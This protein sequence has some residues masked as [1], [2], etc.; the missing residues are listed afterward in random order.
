MEPTPQLRTE[1]TRT[2]ADADSIGSSPKRPSPARVSNQRGRSEPAHPVSDLPKPECPDRDSL[3]RGLEWLLARQREDGCWIGQLFSNQTLEAELILFEHVMDLPPNESRR[4]KIIDTLWH[5]RRDDGTWSIYPGAPTGDP[6]A[7]VESYVALRLAG[8]G[9]D[10]PRL[11]KTREW[12]LENDAMVQVR[13]FTRYWLAIVG[14]IS[15]DEV[16]AL[17]PEHVLIPDFAPLSLAQFASWARVTMVPLAIV[18]ARRVVKHLPEGARCDELFPG[19]RKKAGPKKDL[20]TSG[21]WGKAFRLVD[22][23][24]RTYARSPWRPGR[25][26]A[27][28]LCR[29]WIIA[30]QESDG[31]WGG[32]QPPWFYSLIAL[33]AEGYP[34]DH[35]VMRAGL[36]ALSFPWVWETDDRC[37]L[38]PSVSTVWDTVLTL[39][40]AFEAN[41]DLEDERVLKGVE[42]V[43]DQQVLQPF[44]G[45]AGGWAFEPANRTYPDVDDT[46]IAVLMLA[47]AQ[48]ALSKGGEHARS[49]S[50]R[51]GPAIEKGIEFL[52]ALQCK[53]GG[54]AAFDKDQDARLLTRIPFC[55]FGEVLDPPSVD[56]TAHVLEALAEAGCRRG[57][58]VVDR[59]IEWIRVQQEADGSWFGRWGVN[60]VYGT[61]QVLAGLAALGL[62]TEIGWID[63][64]MQWLLQAQN[65]DGGFGESCASYCN[66]HLRGVGTSTPS[67]TGWGLA[68]LL[69]GSGKSANRDAIDSALAWLRS[70]QRRDGRWPETAYTGTGFPGYGF[71]GRTSEGKADEVRDTSLQRAFMMRYEY[72][73][74]VFPLI[75]IARAQN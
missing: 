51:C 47:K 30:R 38:Q 28:Q 64:G 11:V 13:A 55:D 69:A 71:G 14:E 53:E 35:P 67:Q 12:I 19:G 8:Y 2:T 70:A 5:E 42:W 59:A 54:W 7:T 25:E 15:W 66:E 6:S 27:I 17:P 45:P 75:G 49:I 48:K 62:S 73:S 39:L 46:S 58:P 72:Y 9:P 63:R 18:S 41:I 24:L 32:I 29:E 65:D 20:Q 40:A 23:V 21:A 52:L 4:K 43:I 1:T 22:Q 16:P 50:E 10:E 26:R 44:D 37:Y 68:G 61:S 31:T 34:K 56:V 33:Q 3:E 36:E 60:H 57:E 74:Q